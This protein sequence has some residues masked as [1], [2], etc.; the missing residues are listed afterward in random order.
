MPQSTS[1]PTASR[2]A[3]AAQLTGLNRATVW[4]HPGARFCAM[5]TEERNV[6]GSSTNCTAAI[7]DSSRRSSSPS[8]IESAPKPVPTSTA[9]ANS[10]ITPPTPPG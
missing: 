9:I 10:T 5:N 3:C 6:S 8:A 2:P 1:A 4:I 7:T